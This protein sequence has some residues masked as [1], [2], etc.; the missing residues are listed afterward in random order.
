MTLGSDSSIQ[1]DLPDFL[2]ERSCHR[3]LVGEVLLSAHG[4]SSYLQMYA[5]IQ[6][7]YIQV[8][9]RIKTGR[10]QLSFVHFLSQQELEE[11]SQ[12]EGNSPVRQVSL[13]E[14]S[15]H[16]LFLGQL[17]FSLFLCGSGHQYK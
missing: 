15:P 9:F 6:C 8:L 5:F 16:L 10:V 13:L 11:I 3:I 4:D 17:H 14:G 2:L 1:G 7:V 12:S